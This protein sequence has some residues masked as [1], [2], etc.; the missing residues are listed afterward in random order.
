MYIQRS[1]S[2]ISTILL[3]LPTQTQAH[4]EI[5]V[6]ITKH[7][8]KENMLQGKSDGNICPCEHIKAHGGVEL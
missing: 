7:L 4:T 8:G 6:C 3:W 2:R 5:L 1:D